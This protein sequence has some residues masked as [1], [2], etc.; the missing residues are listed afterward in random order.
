MDTLPEA[1]QATEGSLR[2]ARSREKTVF[3]PTVTGAVPAELDGCFARIGPHSVRNPDSARQPLSADGMVHA[4]RFRAGRAEWYRNRWI[5]G[6]AVSRALGE[7][8]LPGPAHGLSDTANGNLLEHA[9]RLYALGEAGVLPVEL[10]RELAGVARSDFE[11]GLPG[12]FTAHPERDPVTGEL[13]ALTYHH[14]RPHADYVVV[15]TAGRVRRHVPIRLKGTPMLHSMAL[16]TR[17]AILFDLPVVFDPQAAAA[18]SRHPYAWDEG[19]G[20]RLGVMPRE[21]TEDD[22]TWIE[23]DPCYVFHS[24]NAFEA[25][26][27]SIVLDVIRH[28]RVFDTDRTTPTESAPRLWRWRIDRSRAAVHER[29]LDARPQEFPRVDDRRKGTPLR[30]GYTVGYGPAGPA[31][32]HGTALAGSVLY[33]HDLVS[34]ESEVH[35]FGPGQHVGEAVFVPRDPHGPEDDGWLLTLVSDPLRARSGVV[36]LDARDFAA[37]PVAVVHLPG[38]APDGLHASWLAGA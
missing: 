31:G 2:P 20:A 25:P 32:P 35:A 13:F 21:G 19:H 28:D 6:S 26:D 15:D 18:G 33:K 30:F 23:I 38:A 12:G 29:L 8:P 11:A 24:L 3:G 7:P 34:G 4:V 9:G 36:V 14:D 16:T 27:G 17:H 37:E 22:L 10:N 5:R 1:S